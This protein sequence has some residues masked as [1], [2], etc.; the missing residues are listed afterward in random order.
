MS[1]GDFGSYIFKI[2]SLIAYQEYE[3]DR[4]SDGVQ[5][6]LRNN[7]EPLIEIQVKGYAY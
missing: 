2:G 5:E 3:V 4:N 1:I 6:N 7:L